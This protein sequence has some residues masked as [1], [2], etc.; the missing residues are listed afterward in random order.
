MGR[1]NGV[2]TVDMRHLILISAGAI[3]LAGCAQLGIGAGARKVP[4]ATEA[5]SP[6]DAP[7][8]DATLTSA[9]PPPKAAKTADALDTTSAAQ[10]AAA[11]KPVAAAEKSKS[12]GKTTV[13]LGSPTE[14]GFWMKT[15]LVKSETKG[16]VTNPANGKSSAVTLLPIDGPATAGSRMSLP[17]MRLIGLPLTELTDVDVALEG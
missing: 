13:S 4:D 6:A 11:A 1:G 12:L 5:V 3:L 8:P 17:A 7:P 2:I 15:P 10:R 9:P 16:R 14:P